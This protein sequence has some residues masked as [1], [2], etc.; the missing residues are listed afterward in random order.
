MPLSSC[1]GQILC[2]FWLLTQEALSENFEDANELQGAVSLGLEGIVSKRR[3]SAYPSGPCH[4]WIKVKTALW[5][6][7]N[8][9]RWKLFEN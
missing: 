5:R 3:N 2:V 6:E 8:R 9:E 4:S 1:P 7:A